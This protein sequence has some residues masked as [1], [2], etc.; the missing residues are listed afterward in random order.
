VTGLQEEN[1]LEMECSLQSNHACADIYRLIS[2]EMRKIIVK[3]VMEDDQKVG[4][5][6][7]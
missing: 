5:M 2:D 1:G 7:E 6:I 3:Y 4:F